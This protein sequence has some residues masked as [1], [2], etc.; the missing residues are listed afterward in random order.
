MTKLPAPS[1]V[2]VFAVIVVSTVSWKLASSQCFIQLHRKAYQSSK[3]R[4]HKSTPWYTID[5]VHSSVGRFLMCKGDGQKIDEISTNSTKMRH[6]RCNASG[7]TAEESL[8]CDRVKIDIEP[9]VGVV[10]H[11]SPRLASVWVELA[12]DSMC[13]SVAV[14]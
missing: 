7:T 3:L 6:R 13:V 12:T 10:E 1:Q 9:L 4:G 5:V 2:S 8:V 14:S 11:R